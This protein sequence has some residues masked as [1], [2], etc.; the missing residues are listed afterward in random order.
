MSRVSLLLAFAYGCLLRLYPASFRAEF[1]AEMEGVFDQAVAHAAQ[2]GRGA[3]ARLWVRELSTWPGAVGREWVAV[4]QFRL[5]R[6][7]G[8]IVEG[9]PSAQDL[10]PAWPDGETVAMEA[11]PP[12]PWSQALLAALALL[13]PGLTLA[14][15]G[16]PAPWHQLL[17]FGSYLFV[18][19][20]LLL[21]WIRGY[22]RWSYAY[23]GHSLVFPLW[24]SEVSTPG[25]QLLGH[26]FG[27]NEVWGGRAWLGLAF[28]AVLAL[29]WTRSLRPLAR[30]FT[31]IW[32]DPTRLS[33]AL[34]G[35][36]PFFLWLL[37]DEVH[38]PFPVP[39]LVA[40]ALFLAAGAGAYVRAGTS[41]G[42]MLALLAGLSVAWLVSTAGLAAYWHGPRVPGRPPFYWA[43]NVVPMAIAWVVVAAVLLLP[44]GLSVLQRLVPQRR[45]AG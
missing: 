33:L 41:T 6:Q 2:Q 15:W 21:G 39:F 31:G 20:G 27:R 25:L 24:L 23:L 37:F 5:T 7:K 40:S 18:L 34:Y 14:K 45:A 26:S 42:R 44:L 32:R 3:L 12:G 16:V 29:L 9:R 38:P 13:V 43:D 17:V 35:A 28:V 19:L 10:A 4:L 11:G 8:A 36:L 1:A 22:P 30:L